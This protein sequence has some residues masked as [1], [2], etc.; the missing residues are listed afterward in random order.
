MMYADKSRLIMCAAYRHKLY[1][2]H[3]Q[4][5]L[6]GWYTKDWWRVADVPGC[7]AED[8]RTAAANFLAVEDLVMDA[9]TNH[10]LSGLTAEEFMDMY[11]TELK[12]YPYSAN[13]YAPL[14]YDA[15]W[16][17]ALALN[18]TMTHL[19]KNNKSVDNF[20]Y[21]DAEFAQLLSRTL[22]NISTYGITGVINFNRNQ[23]RLNKIWIEQFQGNTCTV[24]T[25]RVITG[26]KVIIANETLTIRRIKISNNPQG[27]KGVSGGIKKKIQVLLILS[28]VAPMYDVIVFNSASFLKLMTSNTRWIW[29]S[30]LFQTRWWIFS[31]TFSLAFGTM[32]VKTWRVYKIFTNKHLDKELNFL[33]DRHLF[34]IVC[35]LVCLDV[36][37][38]TA[39]ELSDPVAGSL[40]HLSKEI[41]PDGN[42]IT[43]RQVLICTSGNE[44]LWLSLWVI[45]KTLLLALGLFLAWE[46]RHVSFPSLNDSKYIGMSVYNVVIMSLINVPL[47]YVV[48]EAHIQARYALIATTLNFISTFTLLVLFVP[49]IAKIMRRATCPEEKPDVVSGIST[50][51]YWENQGCPYC[52]VK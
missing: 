24:I 1:G 26:T 7:S 49:K 28:P 6:P 27:Y 34:G 32:F 41:S 13:G 14:G 50:C 19:N 37:Y 33:R 18:K 51:N 8:I 23:E 3:V 29:I 9:A 20:S 25:M 42:V 44:N 52:N 17:L 15:A 21:E 38:L 46:T 48:G 40:K 16:V 22:L 47:Y 36:V 5:L 45:W 4:W 30:F 39:W 10:T 43:Q 35:G 2:P 11:T 31:L 12:H